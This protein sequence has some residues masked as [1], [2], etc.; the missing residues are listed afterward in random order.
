MHVF[1]IKQLAFLVGDLENSAAVDPSHFPRSIHR[2]RAATAFAYYEIG[3]MLSVT[4]RV[5]Q[6]KDLEATTLCKMTDFFVHEQDLV[7]RLLAFNLCIANQLYLKKLIESFSVG[8]G[9][10]GQTIF[11]GPAAIGSVL[12][13]I[14]LD[15]LDQ[16]TRY[17]FYPLRLSLGRLVHQYTAMATGLHTSALNPF[18]E[19]LSTISL[20]AS[21][22][23]DPVR[24]FL[25]TCPLRTLWHHMPFILQLVQQPGLATDYKLYFLRAFADYNFDYAVLSACPDDYHE[26]FGTSDQIK[27]RLVL[28][29]PNAFKMFADEKSIGFSGGDVTDE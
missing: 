4:E 22:C 3:I 19:H 14:R 6:W 27:G 17:D 2:T 11:K 29:R 25:E 12:K 28:S 24:F 15:E 18:F 21:V 10:E 20:H 23:H 26:A 8:I 1:R 13:E 7:A 5:D 9:E 16:Q